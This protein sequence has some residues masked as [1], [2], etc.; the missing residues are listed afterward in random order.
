MA[1]PNPQY[2]GI[3]KYSSALGTST[4]T[5][6]CSLSLLYVACNTFQAFKIVSSSEELHAL[7]L[8]NAP[9]YSPPNVPK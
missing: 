5:L 9:C 6:M 7:K 2:S 4:M 8:Y 3:H 1:V